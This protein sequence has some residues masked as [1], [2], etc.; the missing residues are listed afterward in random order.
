MHKRDQFNITLI[1]KRQGNTLVYPIVRNI[2]F[3]VE[4]R[5]Q[6]MIVKD[7]EDN[8][9]YLFSKGADEAIFPLLEET[10]K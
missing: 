3:S 2:E 6:S 8:R 4:R 10:F 5:M 1:E 9:V 7:P